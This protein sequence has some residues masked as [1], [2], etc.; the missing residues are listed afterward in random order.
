MEGVFAG[1]A[2]KTPAENQPLAAASDLSDLDLEKLGRLWLTGRTISWGQLYENR[3]RRAPMPGCPF[4]DKRHWAGRDAA[5]PEPVE[6][7]PIV[8]Q[9][10]QPP[11]VETTEP[12]PVETVSITTR[13]QLGT[14]LENLIGLILNK[15]PQ[16]IDPDQYMEDYGFDANCQAKLIQEVRDQLNFEIPPSDLFDCDNLKALSHY[17]S[18]QLSLAEEKLPSNQEEMAVYVRGLIANLLKLDESELPM[19]DYLGDYGFDS[20]T[21]ARMVNYLEETFKIE[22][23]ASILFDCETVQALAYYLAVQLGMPVH[24]ETMPTAQ[25]EEEPEV[26]EPVFQP[27]TVY[28]LSEA[29]KAVWFLLQVDPDNYGYHLPTTISIRQAIDPRIIRQTFE[30]LIINNPAFR[31]TFHMGEIE[32][33]QV[34]HPEVRPFF[35]FEDISHLDPELVEPHIRNQ[36]FQP[37]DLENGPLMRV[38]LFTRA[39]EDHILLIVIHHIIFD[40][41]SFGILVTE[42]SKI[43]SC[44]NQGVA[45]QAPPVQTDYAD[46]VKWQADMLAGDQ[47]K[48]Q[49]AYWEEKLAGELPV[50]SLPADYPRKKNKRY[51]GAV[52]AVYLD[53]ANILELNKLARKNRASLFM[54]LLTAFKVLLMRHTRQTDIIVGSPVAGRPQEQFESLIGFFI[55]MVAL[56]SDLDSNPS[57][58]QLLGSVKR[59]VLESLDN[60]DLPY[61]TLIQKMGIDPSDEVSPIFQTAFNLQSWFQE[62]ERHLD[63]YSSGLG[64]FGEHAEMGALKSI[65]ETGAFDLT[66]EVMTGEQGTI[67]YFKYDPA[68]F[69]LQR[70]ARMAEHYQN[71][72]HAILQD[73]DQPIAWIPMISDWEKQALLE[74]SDPRPDHREELTFTQLVEKRAAEKPDA[75]A[76]V[77]DDWEGKGAPKPAVSLTYREMNEKA[78]QLAHHLIGLGVVP[79]SRVGV[80]IDRS[81][82]MVIAILAVMKAGGAYVPIDPNYPEERVGHILEQ[83]Q[84]QAIVVRE[85]EAAVVKASGAKLVF[86]DLEAETIAQLSNQNPEVDTSPSNLLYVTF[87]SGSTGRP[88]GVMIEHRRLVNV[89]ESWEEAYKLREAPTCHLNMAS[90]SFDVFSGDLAR[91]LGSGAKLVICPKTFLLEPELL[92]GLLKRQGVD[93]AEFV[94][95]VLRNLITWL[96]DTGNN[97]GFFRLLIA[98]SDAWSVHEYADFKRFCS[99]QTRLINSY[100]VTEATIDT[101]WFECG[102]LGFPQA[103]S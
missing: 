23:S 72:L 64:I 25:I 89:Y 11:V 51:S 94:P 90:F 15:D 36:A 7:E 34:V 58:S 59:S 35:H 55:N 13:T 67:A 65:H 28:P 1:Q 31:T 17:L 60:G 9:E 54:V 84:V 2:P 75:T 14:W 32:P 38:A 24:S 47:G 66:L 43:Y 61:A 85:T 12:E 91:A 63:E 21:G 96:K 80:C 22:I 6:A 8:Q 69:R 71:I 53:Q 92:Y 44:L 39:P 86:M 50:L 20:L 68:L 62:T 76:L 45:Y 93:A 83:A 37:F 74:A 18:V 56:R 81:A 30:L 101:T 88:K 27:A 52:H 103:P 19:D 99:P 98:G 82:D 42:L 16:S 26:E 79:D 46:F 41:T 100:G 95:A 70:I 73:P 29:Q 33:E 4:K 57:F 102:D 87:T 77:F 48:S 78:N 97:L 5:P 3:P 10:T 40:G 49:M